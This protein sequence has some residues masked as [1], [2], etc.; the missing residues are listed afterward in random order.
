MVRLRWTFVLIIISFTLLVTVITAFR[1]RDLQKGSHESVLELKKRQKCEDCDVNKNDIKQNLPIYKTESVKHVYEDIKKTAQDKKKNINEKTIEKVKHVFESTIESEEDEDEDG[2]DENLIY[3]RQLASKWEEKQKA[4]GILNKKEIKLISDKKKVTF[5]KDK[6][7]DPFGKNNKNVDHDND[8]DDDDDDNDD[9]D[10]D[11][12]DSRIIESR[13][14]INIPKSKI[15]EDKPLLVVKHVSEDSDDEEYKDDDDKIDDSGKMHERKSVKQNEKRGKIST[16]IKHSKEDDI[17]NPKIKE[18]IPEVK[19]KE[20]IKSIDKKIKV[21]TNKLD[22]TKDKSNEKPKTKDESLIKHKEILKSSID[23]HQ[24]K[25]PA[26]KKE[27]P[28]HSKVDKVTVP[29]KLKDKPRNIILKPLDEKKRVTD[30]LKT[31]PPLNE[32]HDGG[33]KS[34]SREDNRL[35]HVTEALHRRN[36]LKSEFEDFYAFLPTF[37]PNFTR[38]QNPE[39]RRHGQ[40]LLRQLRGTKLWA[41]NMLDS[42]GKIPSGILQGNGIQLGSYDQC[43]ESRAR[44]Q[45]DTGSIVKVQ[46]KYC[47]ARIDLKAEHPELEIPVYL[48]QARNLIKSKIDDP[49]HF[50]PRFSTL[51]WGVCVPSPCNPEDVEN[52][53]RD[54]IKHYQY[55]SGVSIKVK[56]DSLDCH[57]QKKQAW[58]EEWL[59]IPTLLTL[60]LYGVVVL[61]V[62]VATVQDF[63]ARRKVN[64]DTTDDAAN[65][66]DATDK[67]SNENSKQKGENVISVFSLYRT[68]SKL[69]EPATSD[70]ISCIHGVRAIA[71]IALLVAHKFLPIAVTPYTNRLRISEV[72]S[73]PFWSWSRAG[74]M[75]TDCFLL[76]SATLTA[77]RIS[78][79]GESSA[80]KRIA[81]RYLRLTP[82]LIAVILFY[83]YI[84][85]H[86]SSG[87]MWGSLVTKNAEVC[88]QGWW[89]NILYVQN[90]FGFED[91]CAPQTH[92]LAL[93]MQLSILGGVIVWSM[94]SDMP[95]LR[96]IL[97]TLHVWTAFSRYRVTKEHRLTMLAYHGV[98]VSQLYRT[99][100][101]SY[102]SVIHRST[103]YLVGLSLGLALRNN[104]RHSKILMTF[105]W[106]VSGV[107]WTLVWWAGFDSGS[108]QY[109]YSATFAAQYA[110]LAPISS[111]LAIAWLIY[112]VHSGHCEF[113]SNLLCSRP[114]ALISRLSY[115]LYLCQF[116]V[117]LTNAATVKT[118]REFT[119]MS[120]I[121]VQEILWIFLSS[122]VLTLTFIIPMQSLPKILFLMSKT[123]SKENVIDEPVITEKV[124]E[125]S[126]NPRKNE[127]V[128]EPPLI[129]N[130][131]TLIAHREVLEEI[132]EDEVE[133]EHQR[134][135]NEGL[136]EIIEEE[137]DEEGVDEVQ[138]HSNED[139]LEVIEEEEG[140]E[141][142]Y[143]MREE[144]AQRRSFSRNSDRDL[145]D[146]EVTG[147]GNGRDGAQ[148]Y[149]FSRER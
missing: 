56:V 39:C 81:S 118:A 92:Q 123:N 28:E 126:E 15:L 59:A 14:K 137:E 129:R 105:G 136:E 143:W 98:S 86:I 74:W 138:E 17:D 75:Y 124:Q 121:D 84:W 4:S 145:D 64:E 70:E 146:W 97:P 101:L 27:I 116:V 147:N 109:R 89:W 76:L 36:M 9:N 35:K 10:D 96:A 43:L 102:T 30:Q 140:G 8:D 95:A 148:H 46:G 24:L 69:V 57:M 37:A 80:V 60:S 11:D 112:A 32:L 104:T 115:A 108:T 91:M 127:K 33:Q 144:S 45:L 2:G 6:I 7:Q 149:R 55:T 85:D 58:W 25:E 31:D 133:Y 73:S 66:K 1:I 12:D 20:T 87:P 93:D 111:A 51:S 72:V 88:Q 134:N 142:D 38:V 63:V 122:I 52:I 48:A 41:L 65:E 113:L 82:A 141:E 49:G 125:Q 135:N 13:K 23:K 83:A 78:T 132:P 16:G 103:P 79:E 21:L 40:I 77:H 67:G 42:T 106:L 18:N 47:L 119:L 68:M 130:R 53:L 61:L 62:I 128:M 90:Y 107:L 131:Q 3:L 110:A 120:C 19:S 94:Q 117:F 50:V 71:T 139:D 5:S 29:I 26:K 22:Q 100:R 99:A 114:L 54:A 44:V 34:E